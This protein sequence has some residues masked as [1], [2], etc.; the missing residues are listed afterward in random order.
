VKKLIVASIFALST[1]S[2][3]VGLYAVGVLSSAPVNSHGGPVTDYVSLIDNLRASGVTV[4]PAGNISQPFFSIEG[5]IINVKGEQ[6]QVFEYSDQ[7]AAEEDA[8][9]VSPDGN[10]VG[11]TMVQWLDT[12]HFYKIGNLIAIYIGDDSSTNNTLKNLLGTQFA[13]G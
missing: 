12:P 5:Y 8:K 1:V 13:G 3:I 4:S 7:E 11:L 6:I 10:T 2:L 9:L